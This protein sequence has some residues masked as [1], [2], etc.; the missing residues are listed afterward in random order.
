MGDGQRE[1]QT[2]SAMARA[3]TAMHQERM[4]QQTRVKERATGMELPH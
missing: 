2:W 3:L 1:E 4:M